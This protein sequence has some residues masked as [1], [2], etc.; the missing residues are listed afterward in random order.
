[1]PDEAEDDAGDGADMDLADDEEVAVEAPLPA[2]AEVGPPVDLTRRGDPARGWPRVWDDR[3][4][5]VIDTGLSVDD[6]IEGA[7]VEVWFRGYWWDATIFR[8]A[9]RDRTVEVRWMHNGSRTP[10][11]RITLCRRPLAR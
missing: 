7:M 2:D 4:D 11:Y 5:A 6:V 8:V 10:G 9:R 1:L 3:W